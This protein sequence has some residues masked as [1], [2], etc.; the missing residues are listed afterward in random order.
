[1]KG[2]GSLTAPTT[3]YVVVS[4]TN[5]ETIDAG[6]SQQYSLRAG[7]IS[8]TTVVG[9][10]VST[11]FLTQV[12]GT[13]YTGYLTTATT[14]LAGTS[15]SPSGPN[16]AAELNGAGVAAGT[17]VWSDI[18]DVAGGTNESG[19][20]TDDLYLQDLGNSTVVRVTSV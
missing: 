8:G 18:S 10:A 2:L 19:D 3:T 16:L 12:D 11:S 14:T 1:M 5:P 13:V 17:F 6:T 4:F 20:W 9:D 15:V 7:T